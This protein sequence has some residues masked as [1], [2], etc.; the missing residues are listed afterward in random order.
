[1][2]SGLS[3]SKSKVKSQDFYRLCKSMT[4]VISLL[5]LTVCLLSVFADKTETKGALLDSTT[6][7]NLKVGSR[8]KRMTQKK[9]QKGKARKKKVRGNKRRKK[10]SMAMKNKPKEKVRQQKSRAKKNRKQG[11][12]INIKSRKKGKNKGQGKKNI[13]INWCRKNKK[14]INKCRFSRKWTKKNMREKKKRK[15]KSK[16]DKQRKKDAM[17]CERNGRTI[18]SFCGGVQKL[19]ADYRWANNILQ[20]NGRI[21]KIAKV[22]NS[23]YSIYM[24][25]FEQ[26]SRVLE[27]QNIRGIGNNYIANQV[28]FDLKR[29]P[30]TIKVKKD[31]TFLK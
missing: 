31:I 23:K 8:I 29:C 11:K 15:L 5:I 26:N 7:E 10:G 28:Y 1:M 17:W 4:S 9:K 20:Q 27:C 12:K 19:F 18:K 13:K 22:L 6:S 21:K 30:V 2:L 14:R 24:E 25:T 3:N 16:R